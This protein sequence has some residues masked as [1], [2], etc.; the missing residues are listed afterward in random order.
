[1]QSSTSVSLHH[2]TTKTFQHFLKILP[3]NN[4][5]HLQIYIHSNICL[6]YINIYADIENITLIPSYAESSHLTEYESV[7][8]SNSLSGALTLERVTHSFLCFY[9]SNIN[10][11]ACASLIHMKHVVYIGDYKCLNNIC[12]PLPKH[13][14]TFSLCA[15]VFFVCKCFLCAIVFFVCK[16]FL[17][18]QLFS[19]C[20]IVFF[21]VN[22]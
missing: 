16:C 15:I 11:F 13:K 12:A 21:I 4:I 7:N 19:L 1:M 18:V 9:S 20:A 2:F 5:E 14:D 3:S 10:G 8:K 17:C 6:K 22:I